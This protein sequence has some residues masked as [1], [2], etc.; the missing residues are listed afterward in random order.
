MYK[1][2][3]KEEKKERGQNQIKTLRGSALDRTTL[4]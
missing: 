4:S 2:K 1:T 3:D